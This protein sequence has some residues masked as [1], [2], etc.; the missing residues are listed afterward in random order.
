MRTLAAVAFLLVLCQV[1][2]KTHQKK[3]DEET[4]EVTGNGEEQ[5]TNPC[6]DHHCGLGH[7]C[8]LDEDEN[9]VCVCTRKCHYGGEGAIKVCSTL[10]ATFGSE[11][12]LYRQKC[13]CQQHKEDCMDER[14][15]KGH[16][17]YYGECKELP[18]C[19]A[20]QMEEFPKRM[21]NW[22]YLVMEELDRRQDLPPVAHQMA[23]DS[24]TNN[25]P[26][27]LP[28]IWK[29]CDLDKSHDK[30]INPHEL[31]PITAPLKPLE[32][33]TAPFLEKCDTDNDGKIALEEWGLCLGLDAD[34]IEDRCDDL[35]N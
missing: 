5:R 27:L 30:L 8:D 25:K 23:E 3:E 9:P 10:N 22:L 31:M 4:N 32:H 19:T 2:A 28:V 12:E 29:F 34:E 15:K 35:R 16:L 11:C 6:A 21:R 13:L 24:K 1:L 18:A 14:Y 7:E 17:D 20:E 33:C 26:W